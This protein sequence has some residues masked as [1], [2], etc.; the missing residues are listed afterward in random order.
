MYNF[1]DIVG[2]EKIIANLKST[3]IN[4]N[5]NHSYIINGPEKSGK[6]LIAKSF[7]MLLMCENSNKKPCLKCTS[8]KSFISN[9]NPDLFFIKAKNK[10]ILIEDIREKVIKNV[11]TKAFKYKYKIFI[12]DSA[13][14]MTIQ[15]QN[16]ILKTIEEPLPNIIFILI[17]KNY[18]RLLSTI[19]SR[20]IIFKMKPISPK[21]IEKYLENKNVD[22]IKASI[23]ASYAQGSLGVAISLST[24][25]EFVELREDIIQDID[26]LD[27]LDLIQMYK[28][29]DKL[30]KKRE[31]IDIILNIFLITYRDALIFKKIG[32]EKNLI[33]KDI[34]KLII[35]L[36][37]LSQKNLLNKIDTITNTKKYLN[38]N[39]NLY[40]TMECLFL[41]LKEK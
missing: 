25:N 40:I 24:S 12:I 9:N 8:C 17:T 35:K 34:K 16:S 39:A 3:I 14:T 15:A 28:F 31:E 1:D 38:E 22:A 32:N 30:D 6:K 29:I 20:C 5:V 37:K 36:S 21:I 13:D 2:N 18:K 33:Q 4:G 11:K 10:N 26:K 41:K 19:L 7:S 27:D 23:F